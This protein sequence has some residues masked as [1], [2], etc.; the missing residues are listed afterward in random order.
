MATN[1]EKFCTRRNENKPVR[2]N[3]WT[4]DLHENTITHF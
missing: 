1:L 2:N 4:K 3:T